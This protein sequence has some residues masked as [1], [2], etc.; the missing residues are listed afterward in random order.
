MKLTQTY[1]CPS[2]GRC[3]IASAAAFLELNGHGS[4]FIEDFERESLFMECVSIRKNLA[5][6]EA[7]LKAVETQSPNKWIH[8]PGSKGSPIEKYSARF[9]IAQSHRFELFREEYE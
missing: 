1:D 8:P 4:K 9:Q 7:C 3:Q 5:Q 6:G 2:S